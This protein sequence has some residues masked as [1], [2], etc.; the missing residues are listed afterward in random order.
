MAES[1]CDDVAAARAPAEVEEDVI[2]LD[3]LIVGLDGD[4]VPG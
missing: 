3:V 1:A 4:A 2:V